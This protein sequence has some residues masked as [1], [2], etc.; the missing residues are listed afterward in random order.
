MAQDDFRDLEHLRVHLIVDQL[1]VFLHLRHT[2]LYFLPICKAL[3]I[4][5]FVILIEEGIYGIAYPLPQKHFNENFKNNSIPGLPDNHQNQ[6]EKVFL[7]CL[8]MLLVNEHDP[9]GLDCEI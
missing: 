9:E 2:F 7:N 3:N 5:C 4:L 8:F 1:G 6:K